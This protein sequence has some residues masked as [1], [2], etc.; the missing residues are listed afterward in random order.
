MMM[1]TKH[2]TDKKSKNT[3]SKDFFLLHLYWQYNF[4]LPMELPVIHKKK[5]KNYAF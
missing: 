2:Y 1:I 5:M 4:K 3:M